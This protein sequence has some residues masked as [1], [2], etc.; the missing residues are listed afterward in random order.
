MGHRRGRAPDAVT[1]GCLNPNRAVGSEAESF[2]LSSADAQSKWSTDILGKSSYLK[3]LANLDPT[4]KETLTLC[5]VDMGT[6]SFHMVIVKADAKGNVVV[7][8]QMKEEVRIIGGTGSFNVIMEEPEARAI[9]VLKRIQNIANTKDCDQVRLVATSAVREARNSKVFIRHVQEATG[10]EVEVISGQEEA[11]LVYLG[12]MQAVPIREK[13]VLLVDIGGGSTEIL[14]GRKGKPEF[15]ISLQL[16]HLRLFE[17]CMGALNEEGTIPPTK[18]EDCRAKIQLILNETGIKEELRELITKARGAGAAPPKPA[19]G[20]SQAIDV[21]VGCSGTIERVQAM[22]S[23]IK[24]KNGVRLPDVAQASAGKARDG[25]IIPK[26]VENFSL[27]DSSMNQAASTKGQKV[28]Y[29]VHD[30]VEE[31]KFTTR[32]LKDLISVIFSCKTRKERAA[33]PGMNIK[34][35]DLIVTGA[36]IL[37]GIMEYLELGAM[38]VS[39]FALREGVIFDSLTKFIPG[40][41][42]T[43]CIRRDSLMHLATRFDTENRL[44]SAKH[45]AHL[46]KQ[47]V[48]SLRKGPRPPKALALMDDRIEFLLEAAILLHSVGIFV[49]HSKH[50]KH[51]YYIIKNSD[52]LLGFMP[53]EIEILA[54][55]ALYHRKKYPNPKKALMSGLPKK[56]QEAIVVMTAIIRVCIALDRRNTACAIESVQVLQDGETDSCVLVATPGV[57]MEGVINDISFELWAV[58][59]EL[60]YFEKV[61]EKDFS[62]VEGDRVEPGEEQTEVS[63]FISS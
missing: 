10:L 56:V 49:N 8:E 63:S 27:N 24:A 52:I 55:L 35:V 17:Q 31:G 5:A 22:V 19:F 54:L 30:N 7:V 3:N 18:V 32:E 61:M 58:K 1:V 45:S 47:L 43:P 25:N 21:A 48:E 2:L 57:D 15:A 46:A 33:L 60:P 41:K 38:I 50:H 26:A 59:Q 6:N 11:R 23:A 39:P 28:L 12:A 62:I 37:E 16:G 14:Y 51:A 40:F 9:S 53:M 36:L 42:P 34:R 13:D 20:L 29:R 4:E 44:R